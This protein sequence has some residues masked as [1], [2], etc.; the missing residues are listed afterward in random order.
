MTWTACVKDPPAAIPG[1]PTTPA[2]T[3]TLPVTATAPGGVVRTL[4]LTINVT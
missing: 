1:A 2:G 4:T 3:Y